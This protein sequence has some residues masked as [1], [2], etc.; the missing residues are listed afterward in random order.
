M[1]K[2]RILVKSILL[3]QKLWITKEAALRLLCHDFDKSK[4]RNDRVAVDAT[5][6]FNPLASERE[7]NAHTSTSTARND[8]AGALCEK[9]ILVGK[10]V[11]KN[12]ILSIAVGLS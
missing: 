4:S 8:R 11:F 3:A 9:W 2:K 1:I 7:S 5:R 6:I 10:A 12:T